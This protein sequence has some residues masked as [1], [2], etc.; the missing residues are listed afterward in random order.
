MS[1][2]RNSSH[3]SIALRIP[4]VFL[5]KVFRECFLKYVFQLC[6]C[7]DMD[8]LNEYGFM[9]D[10]AFARD[11]RAHPECGNQF[12]LLFWRIRHVSRPM[13]TVEWEGSEP[14]PANEAD[15]RRGFLT[16]PP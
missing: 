2:S 9:T 6:L 12:R 10:G 5:T 4:A 8:S 16:L 7:F 11:H 14:A 3:T 13:A 1:A 15:I